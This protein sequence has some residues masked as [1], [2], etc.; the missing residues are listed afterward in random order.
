MAKWD[1]LMEA[2][3]ELRRL[4][5][6]YAQ[7]SEDSNL[8]HQIARKVMRA[9]GVSKPR[10]GKTTLTRLGSNQTEISTPNYDILIS[11]STPVAYRDNN[12]M[13]VFVTSKHF[14]PTTKKHINKWLRGRKYTEISQE[15]IEDVMP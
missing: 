1:Y 6:Q 5:R 3:A 13:K 4:L 11:Y 14:R 2:D 8:A 15:D 9:E 12:T 10:K 7:D